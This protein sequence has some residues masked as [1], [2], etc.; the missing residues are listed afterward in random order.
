MVPSSSPELVQRGLLAR[1]SNLLQAS[2]WPELS[3]SRLHRRL[4]LQS[5]KESFFPA[6][7]YTLLN[8]LRCFC[9]GGGA[10]GEIRC[11]VEVTTNCDF[12][13][14]LM[15]CFLFLF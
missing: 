1:L 3:D 15:C 13:H 14:E 2:H 10:D 12:W 6:A 5:K 11:A 8:H 4:E 7:R 9:T